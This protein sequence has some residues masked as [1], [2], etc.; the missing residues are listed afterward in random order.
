MVDTGQRQLN[1]AA[2]PFEPRRLLTI[3]YGDSSEFPDRQ[4]GEPGFECRLPNWIQ[5][6]HLQ[7]A[8]YWCCQF[9]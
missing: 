1:A 2:T 9:T 4:T 3:G 7:L 5:T 6:K 8:T